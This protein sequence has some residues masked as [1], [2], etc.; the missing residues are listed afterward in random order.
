MTERSE[1][2]PPKVIGPLTDYPVS[3]AGRRKIEHPELRRE[4]LSQ[5]AVRYLR[6]ARMVRIDHL[7]LPIVHSGPGESPGS[8]RWV[9][10]VPTHPAHIV[11]SSLD[12]QRNRWTAVDEIELPP[13]PLFAGRSRRDDA[14]YPKSPGDR[15]HGKQDHGRILAGSPDGDPPE[16]GLFRRLPAF[17]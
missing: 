8:G 7:I 12:R 16:L 5:T 9:P 10:N 2:R 17:R 1:E 6:F 4:I 13:N 11:V 14:R 15:L 3:H